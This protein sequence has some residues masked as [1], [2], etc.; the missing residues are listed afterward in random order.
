MIFASLFFAFGVLGTSVVSTTA[1]TAT[2]FKSSTSSQTT[3]TPTP[4]ATPTPVKYTLVYPGILPDN[5]L[6]PIKMFRDKIL[7]ILTTDPLKKAELSLLYSDKRLGAGKVLIEGGKTPLGLSTLEKGEK[8][9]AKATSE[10]QSAQ[11]R[12]EDIT[13]FKE[14]FNRAAIKHR[15]VLESLKNRIPDE[16]KPILDN[17]IKY[18]QAVEKITQ[19]E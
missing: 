7:F 19:E 1:Q 12:G 11:K 8:Y 2:K 5:F 13:T 3:S 16:S 4:E 17:L 15:E 6:Y 18:S 9:L 14:K 10:M